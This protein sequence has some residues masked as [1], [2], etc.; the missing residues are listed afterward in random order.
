[1]EVVA[2]VL[3]AAGFKFTEPIWFKGVAALGDNRLFVG[4]GHDV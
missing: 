1:M 3:T 4:S 2:V